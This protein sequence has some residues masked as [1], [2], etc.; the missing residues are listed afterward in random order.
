MRRI[1]P[2]I[3][4][5]VLIAATPAFMKQDN[6]QLIQDCA[7]KA[8]EGTIYLKDF[9]VSLPE[10][11]PNEKPP[12]YRQAI[13]L[14][15]DNIYRFNICNQQGEAV[16]RIFDTSR[17]LVSSYDQQS[18][19]SYNPINFGCTKTGQYSIVITFKDG[20]AGEAIGIM[21]HVTKK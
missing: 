12:M 17:M 14:R 20:K 8:G 3:L 4:S 7:S 1:I 13:L 9:V 16:I 15:G 2:A 19:K 21:S 5:F 18:G 6:Q 10:A 11:K